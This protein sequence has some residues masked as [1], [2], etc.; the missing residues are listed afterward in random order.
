MHSVADVDITDPSPT[1]ANAPQ[2]KCAFIS[3]DG[4]VRADGIVQQPDRY[5]YWDRKSTQSPRI[6]RGA[7]LSYAAASFL[8]GGL[9]VSHASFD[10]VTGFDTASSTVEVETGITLFAVH[11]FLSSLGLYLPVQP[12]HGRIT[13]G[14]CIAADV[15][16]K[17][18]ARDGT[19]MNQVQSLT[20]FHPS[21][22]MLELSRDREPELFRLT[23]GGYGLTGHIVR[24]RLR[25]VPLPAPAVE[26]KAAAFSDA[27]VGLEQLVHAAREAD[28]AYTWHDMAGAGKTFGSGYV[29]QARFVS[30]DYEA[31]PRSNDAESPQ[32]SAA[33][34]AAWP[35]ALLNS[36][37]VRALNVVYRR[38]QR[39]ALA[40]KTMPLQDALFPVHK[41]QLYFK[42]FGARGF[43]EY[44]VIL[45]LEAMRDY[46]G[47]IRMSIRQRRLPITL[48][49][50]KAF[51]GPRD[52]LRFTGEGVCL[53]L[54]LPRGEAANDFMPFL[55]ERVIAL[56][57]VPN[58][59]KDS[60]LSRAVVDACYPGA[61]EFRAALRA[62]DPKR[63]FRSH[64][65]E[66]L[67]L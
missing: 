34:R 24:A 48:A 64:L 15:H 5:R 21:H 29:F 8:D 6:S 3:F 54:N 28:F 2:A 17:N 35:A 1:S 55:D 49:S 59:I 53:A 4:G 66:R 40:G 16:G 20:L 13:V 32:L 30:D 43:H 36:L 41:A 33:G 22:G 60:R 44:Q 56:G 45:P 25:A 52:L 38:Q 39:P 14:G 50:A 46:L 12:G 31:S 42:L 63:M 51:D 9:T 67:G 27:M 61:G 7:G 11:R 65:S 57:G 23:C 62:F 19:F 18:H 10:R 58:I 26:L 47:A 37:S